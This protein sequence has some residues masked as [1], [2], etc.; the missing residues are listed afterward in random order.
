MN[1]NDIKDIM[2]KILDENGIYL[3]EDISSELEVDSLTYMSII[4][5]IEEAFNIVIPEKYLTANAPS[6]ILEF[7][8]F[9]IDILNDSD[10]K[11]SNTYINEHS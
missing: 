7:C 8:D 5:G 2:I 3:C 4:V 10:T 9:A 11:L 6:S 1:S